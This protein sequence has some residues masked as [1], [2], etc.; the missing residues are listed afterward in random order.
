VF[1][2]FA[3]WLWI[4]KPFFDSLPEVFFSAGFRVMPSCRGLDLLAVPF[5]TREEFDTLAFEPP[6]AKDAWLL[7]D[8]V[9]LDDRIAGDFLGTLPVTRSFW[10]E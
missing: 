1:V 6:G 4:D 5:E 3:T 2:K 8:S 7:L 9:L 10:M